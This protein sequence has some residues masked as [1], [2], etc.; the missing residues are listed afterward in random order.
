MPKKTFSVRIDKTLLDRIRKQ[1][2]ED[3]RST[4]NLIA[5]ILLVEFPVKKA[6]K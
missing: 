6:K 5:R 3:G 2:E 1:A 4:N